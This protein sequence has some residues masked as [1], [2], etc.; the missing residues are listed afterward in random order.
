MLC[1]RVGLTHM[2]FLYSPPSPPHPLSSKLCN[3]I[4]QS[5]PVQVKQPWRTRVIYHVNLWR[6]FFHSKNNGKQTKPNAWF[7]GCKLPSVCQITGRGIALLWF[8]VNWLDTT[9]HQLSEGLGVDDTIEWNTTYRSTF[10]YKY[11]LSKYKHYL[12]KYRATN[13]KDMAV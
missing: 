11:F 13:Y 5:F 3:T 1:I 10:Q 6:T 4:V 9:H 8:N 12:S 2:A 7:V